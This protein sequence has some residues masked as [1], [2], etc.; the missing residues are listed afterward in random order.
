MML[1]YPTIKPEIMLTGTS[2]FS[3][4]FN[5]CGKLYFVICIPRFFHWFYIRGLNNI[6]NIN[7]NNITT[8]ILQQYYNN[9]ITTILQQQYYYNITIFII[10][11]YYH[12][13][14]Q[15]GCSSA[16]SPSN[17]PYTGTIITFICGTWH[18]LDDTT[19]TNTAMFIS[20]SEGFNKDVIF[21][22][23][24]IMTEDGL[25]LSILVVL[26]CAAVVVSCA[27]VEL[28]CAAVNLKWLQITASIAITTT[29][30]F[31]LS[32]IRSINNTRCFNHL[33]IITVIFV[34]TRTLRR[35]KTII[36]SKRKK[37]TTI[38][39]ILFFLKYALRSHTQ[40]LTNIK[41]PNLHSISQNIKE[42]VEP[43]LHSISQN[44]K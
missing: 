15:K 39:T 3:H 4:A 44:I 1:S 2:A 17:Y 29:A 28:F 26:V 6:N 43:N 8:T 25:I 35:Y 38:L 16:S 32:S 23:E 42:T 37:I 33:L 12:K 22:D 20:M 36:H 34:S 18:T 41:Q 11:Q 27:T 21:N 9:N 10:L 31:M 40:D 5:S 24:V 19:S 13:N 30:H 7:I 14:N